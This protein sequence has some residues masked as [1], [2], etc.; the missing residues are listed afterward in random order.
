M[1]LKTNFNQRLTNAYR[2]Q[3]QDKWDCWYSITL[4]NEVYLVPEQ[5]TASLR[6]HLYVTRRANMTAETRTSSLSKTGP[7]A[8]SF[9]A[10]RA[11]ECQEYFVP[12]ATRHMAI[13]AAVRGPYGA[14]ALFIRQPLTNEH[15]GKC[16]PTKWK[17]GLISF[18]QKRNQ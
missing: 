15:V 4:V 8:L 2:L 16:V 7:T 5:I 11:G 1:A 14:N 6:S 13:S 17:S 18:L 10:P 12:W 3:T 9:W